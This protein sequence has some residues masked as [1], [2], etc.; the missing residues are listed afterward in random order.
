MGC[1]GRVV[2]NGPLAEKQ[3][4]V[5][6]GG[7]AFTAYQVG[8]LKAL[9]CGECATTNYQ[10][11]APQ[12]ITGT[13]GG[14]LNGALLTSMLD[15]DIQHAVDYL[16]H[17]WLNILAEKP[18]GCSNGAYRYRATP[19]SVLNPACYSPNPTRPFIEF[20]NDATFLASDG[21]R[22]LRHILTTEE[23]VQRKIVDLIDLE[24]L[25]DAT[26]YFQTVRQTVSFEAIRNSRIALTIA[27]TNWDTG[28][29]A[30]FGNSEMTDERGPQIVLASASIPGIFP[31]QEIDGASY[32]D[33]S[34]L[35]NAP[36][37]IP[38][39]DGA[40]TIHVV[41][42]LTLQRE[43]PRAH[44]SSTPDTLWRINQTQ[45]S[46][47]LKQDLEDARNINLALDFFTGVQQP[48]PVSVREE[49]AFMHK[50]R[51]IFERI[52]QRRPYR[53]LTIH[54]YH[55]NE[56]LG[57]VVGFLNF[58]QK[59]LANYIDRGRQD[60]VAH[61]CVANQCILPNSPTGQIQSGRE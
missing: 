16:E 5:L 3:A 59:R 20:F 56:E 8:V 15:A 41:T 23:S 49:E 28:E 57:E 26:Q 22:R 34:V 39:E 1:V 47:S 48:T 54:I 11:F 44:F 61:D 53:K 30:I 25:F 12:S 31:P 2:V 58:E 19:A 7:G 36:L 55:P 45:W 40:N 27:A 4:L 38:I 51:Q 9:L 17:V 6:S 43:I 42:D 29:L 35:L 52:Q 13:S 32:V 18:G 60:A 10:P 37:R 50:A 33:G 21:L 46:S 14:G 24:T